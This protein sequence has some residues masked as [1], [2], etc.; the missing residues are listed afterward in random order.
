MCELPDCESNATVVVL[1]TTPKGNLSPT[2][3]CESCAV[4]V[5]EAED[6][7]ELIDIGA[8]AVARELNL[9]PITVMEVRL[10]LGKP[11]YSEVM[12]HF[13]SQSAK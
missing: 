4:S 10:K 13:L 12:T 2:M 1:Y 5:D 7:I 6:D 8:W 11:P 9:D 3:A